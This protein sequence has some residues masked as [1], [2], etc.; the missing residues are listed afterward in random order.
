P[1]PTRISTTR[2]ASAVASRHPRG[3]RRR[4]KASL[5]SRAASLH[6]ARVA[7]GPLLAGV[8]LAG[9]GQPTLRATRATAPL[10]IDGKL[11]DAARPAAPARRR[12]PADDP[13]PQKPPTA[14][15]APSDPPPVQ[16][17]YDDEP[18]YAGITSPQSK[19]PTPARLP[20]RDRQGVEA[21]WV[22]VDLG[23]R[24]D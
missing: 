7:I 8:L 22:E 2:P 24:G 5:E 9:P 18:I 19:P 11:D 16:P 12:A 4:N 21:D 14:A 23:T 10:K 1:T 15:A 3:I 6:G 20:R 13:S 17:L